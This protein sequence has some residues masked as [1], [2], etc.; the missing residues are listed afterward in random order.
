MVPQHSIF[1]KNERQPL[2]GRSQELKTELKNLVSINIYGSLKTVQRFSITKKLTSAK[3]GD[4][5]N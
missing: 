1:N 3:L 4:T 2:E 5:G